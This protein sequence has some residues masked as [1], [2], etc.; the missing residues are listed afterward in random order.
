MF[1]AN[2]TMHPWTKI[3]RETAVA[4]IINQGRLLVF[5]QVQTSDAGIQVPAGSIEPYETPSQAVLRKARE[6]TGLEGLILREYLGYAVVDLTRFG[7]KET[8]RRHFFHV[9]LPGTAPVE[10][11]RSKPIPPDGLSTL[12]ELEFYWVNLPD[13]VPEL[14]AELDALVGGINLSPKL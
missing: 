8:H 12:I 6:E 2:L 1:W 11:R 9:E 3:D 5:R 10:W 14:L 7:L 13:Q 4:Y